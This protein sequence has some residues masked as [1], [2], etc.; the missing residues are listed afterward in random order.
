MALPIVAVCVRGKGLDNYM[1]TYALIDPG[2]TSSYCSDELARLLDVPRT[3]YNCNLSTIHERDTPVE[4]EF[5]NLQVSTLHDTQQFD[6]AGVMVHPSL[7]IGLDNLAAP[8]VFH[9]WPHLKDLS[10]PRLDVNEVLLIGSNFS[11]SDP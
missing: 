9:K 6:M 10:M 11:G 5:V 3:R 8:E 7:N 4:A 2:G 1:D